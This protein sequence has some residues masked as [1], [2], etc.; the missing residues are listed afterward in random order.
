MSDY[1]GAWQGNHMPVVGGEDS[2][3]PLQEID[4]NELVHF[5]SIWIVLVSRYCDKN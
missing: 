2:K 4:L 3:F 1:S 5:T